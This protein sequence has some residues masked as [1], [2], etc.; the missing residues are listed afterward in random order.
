MERICRWYVKLRTT[1]NID[2]LTIS[3]ELR[4]I[5]RDKAPSQLTIEK[6]FLNHQ[7]K[8]IMHESSTD[9]SPKE[10]ELSIDDHFSLRS[11][12]SLTALFSSIWTKVYD[13]MYQIE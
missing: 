10:T 7:E 8:I 1:L 2:P 4:T 12:Y 13:I 3:R 11:V 9:T 5:Y 6:W